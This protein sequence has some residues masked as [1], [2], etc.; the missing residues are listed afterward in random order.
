MS[1]TDLPD[2]ADRTVEDDAQRWADRIGSSVDLLRSPTHR[3]IRK[4]LDSVA[5]LV[6][7]ADADLRGRLDPEGE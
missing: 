3:A 5:E 1:T 7:E 4:G 2:A 6:A